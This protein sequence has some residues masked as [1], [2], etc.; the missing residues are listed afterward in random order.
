[1]TRHSGDLTV[2]LDFTP[3]LVGGTGRSGTT[4]IGGLLGRHRDVRASVPREIKCVTEPSGLLDVC[5]GPQV[6]AR[7]GLRARALA[8]FPPL[9]RRALLLGFQRRMRGRWWQRSNRKDRASGLHLTLDEQVRDDL[10]ERL[11]SDVSADPIAAGRDFLAGLVRSQADDG[12]ESLWVDTS[13]PNIAEAGRI[14]RILPEARFIRMVR[15]GRSTAASVMAERWGPSD[16]IEAISWWERHLVRAEAGLT[17]V[18]H[19]S[20]LTLQLEDLVVRRRS[21]SYAQLLEFLSL[22]DDPSM[23]RFFD[24]RMPADRVRPD[25]WRH[26]VPDRVV[27]ERAYEEAAGRLEARGIAV[28]AAA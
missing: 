22:D 6:D 25:S 4:V 11:V 9:H 15:D 19:E 12:G 20:V 23:R 3:V 27:F 16:P 21:D 26:K 24:R 7:V 5:V 17:D 18:P 14:H 1:M 8:A 2:P 28:H 10:V 13:P